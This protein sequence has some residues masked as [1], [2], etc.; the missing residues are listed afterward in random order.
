[1]AI[2]LGLQHALAMAGGIVTPPLL[3]GGVAGAALSDGDRNYLVSACLIWS[4]MGTI[5]QIAR[6]KLWKTNFY[7]GTGI[8]SVLGTSFAFVN[9]GLSF[10]NSE[11]G[12]KGMCSLDASGNKLPCPGAFGAILGTAI[13]TGPL[14][15]LCAFIPT[16][17]IRRL[18]PP[19]EFAS[20]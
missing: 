12:P 7:Y 5:L 6:F 16:K 4:G 15:I 3:L 1:M 2:I 20:F 8:I 14:G 18:F 9:V 11:Y 17:V 13:V 10:I 19:R